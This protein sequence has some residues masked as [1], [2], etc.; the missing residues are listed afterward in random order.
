MKLQQRPRKLKKVFVTSFFENSPRKVTLPSIAVPDLASASLS[1]GFGVGNS[2]TGYLFLLEMQDAVSV[3]AVSVCAVP[4][5]A[6]VLLVSEK[7][8][9]SE[10]PVIVH[11]QQGRHLAAAAPLFPSRQS[12][13]QW[14][15]CGGKHPVE[16]VD[17]LQQT[18]SFP[19]FDKPAAQFG[20][21]L[22][23]PAQRVAGL[24]TALNK[25]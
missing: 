17:P 19:A 4:K 14:S 13:C 18:S 20:M 8:V 11:V 16:S 6:S 15:G 12:S 5:V 25:L 22:D 10:S 9:I 3:C 24:L 7:E 2:Q 1:E 21:E 23:H